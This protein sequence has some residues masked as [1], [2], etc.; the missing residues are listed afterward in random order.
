[1]NKLASVFV[2]LLCS[3]GM[4]AWGAEPPPVDQ[5]EYQAPQVIQLKAQTLNTFNAPEADQ[6]VAVD[7]QYFYP[8]DNAVIGKY[9]KDNGEFVA[10]WTGTRTRP[11]RH[12]NSCY[13]RDQQLWCANS[14]YS[15]IPI[16]SSVEVFTTDPL[17]PHKSHSLGLTDAGSLVWFE[18]WQDG[19]IAGFAHYSKKGGESFKGS[20]YSSIVSYDD[21]WRRT[22]GWAL[23]PSLVNMMAPYAASG[24]AIGPGGYLYL[25]GHD[26]PQMYV[27]GLPSM[28]P[29]LVHLATIDL[30]AQGQA[31]SFDPAAAQQ[32]WVIDRHAKKVRQILLPELKL[33]T[34]VAKPFR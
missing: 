29:E 16:A 11:V 7:D 19:F 31:F 32:V 2:V 24:G 23:P 34:D 14:N 18:H 3:S 22:G 30:Q 17:Q 1:M 6:G 8:V 26:A 15:E 21:R 20:E 10:R 9:R 25:M 4:N 28:G 13:A 5:L 33:T 12:I 27:M